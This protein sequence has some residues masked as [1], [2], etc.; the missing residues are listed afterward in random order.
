MIGFLI[1]ILLGIVC[2]HFLLKRIMVGN[3]LTLSEKKSVQH[4]LYFLKKTHSYIGGALIILI[5]IHCYFNDEAQKNIYLS[6]LIFFVFFLE[7]SGLVTKLKF[8]P[9]KI[10]RLCYLIHINWLTNLILLGLALLGHALI[11]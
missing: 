6:L 7:L 10:R 9:S 11:D 4:L 5:V 2:V 1:L 8:I 3:I